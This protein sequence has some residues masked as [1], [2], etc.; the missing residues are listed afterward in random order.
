MRITITVFESTLEGYVEWMVASDEVLDGEHIT[1]GIQ[2]SFNLAIS[3]AVQSD[4]DLRNK[5][6]FSSSLIEE[7]A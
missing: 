6:V 4:L 2:D 5:G 1:A 3:E 7:E